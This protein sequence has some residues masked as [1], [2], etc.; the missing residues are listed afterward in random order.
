MPDLIPFQF[1]SQILGVITDDN[2]EHWWIA[3]EVCAGLELTNVSQALSR[4]DADEKADIIINDVTGR[5]QSTLIVNEPGL[6]RLALSSRKKSAQEFKRWLL[7]EVLPQL[8]KTG[9]YEIAA[10]PPRALTHAEMFLEQAKIN[11]ALEQRQDALD[12]RLTAIEARRPPEGK[13]RPGSW[14]RSHSKP[15]LNPAIM[16]QLNAACRRREEPERWRPEGYD[17]PVPYYTAETLAAAYEEVTRQLSFIHDPGVVY[18][19]QRGRHE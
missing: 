7:H 16:E 4:L 12:E 1:H 6:Y 3:S 18:H 13:L 5:P 2:G 10:S 14:L 8:R 9:R 15:H 11:V 19:R 17:W